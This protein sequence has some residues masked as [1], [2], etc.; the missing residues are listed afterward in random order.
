[1]LQS[2][3]IVRDRPAPKAPPSFALLSPFGAD[4][5]EPSYAEG[6]RFDSASAL[7]DAA[8]LRAQEALL[9][10]PSADLYVNNVDAILFCTP[11]PLLL[12]WT[13][14]LEPLAS[15]PMLWWCDDEPVVHNCTLADT[16]DGILHPGMT[17][18]EL[19]WALLLASKHYLARTQWKQ[20]REQLIA[21]LEDRKWIDRA[22]S[23]LSEVKNITE[24]EAYEF[25]RKQAMNERRRLVDVAV[26][27]VKV[28]SLLR[29]QNPR[30]RTR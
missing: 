19:H 12:K 9:P 11:Y 24:A 8:G 25:L 18:A 26:S 22:K 1:M 28:Y 5:E 20:E 13:K 27:I 6:T 4:D 23:I 30:G 10:E 16:V 17:T 14:L 7:F 29:E 15:P 21:K 3:L 2:F